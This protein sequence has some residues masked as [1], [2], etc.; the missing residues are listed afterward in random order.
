MQKQRNGQGWQD[1]G[2]ILGRAEGKQKSESNR[3]AKI[4]IRTATLIRDNRTEESEKVRNNFFP[5]Q[6]PSSC[7]GQNPTLES[8]ERLTQKEKQPSQ[9]II[10]LCIGQLGCLP[11]FQ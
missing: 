11:M 8:H 5:A 4:I 2:R 9:S 7:T 3:K 6:T 1:S 10:C